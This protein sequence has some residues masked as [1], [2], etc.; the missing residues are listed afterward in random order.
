M[1]SNSEQGLHVPAVI[2]H[3]TLLYLHD[4]RVALA[5][6]NGKKEIHWLT[7]MDT[8]K[9]PTSM[10][11]WRQSLSGWFIFNQGRLY[12][13]Q[14]WERSKVAKRRR[15]KNLSLRKVCWFLLNW[16]DEGSRLRAHSTQTTS[17]EGPKI[18]RLSIT[19]FCGLNPGQKVSKDYR[20]FKILLHEYFKVIMV[21]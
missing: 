15:V 7:H 21:I 6:S 8:L 17:I 20:N 14:C 11:A 13:V 1:L 12:C 4:V 16:A 5:T 2:K 10:H 9:T 18:Q 19:W 3:D